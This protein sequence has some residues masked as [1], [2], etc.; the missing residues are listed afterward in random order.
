MV[1]ARGYLLLYVPKIEVYL[2]GS[3]KRFQ[4]A[5]RSMPLIPLN[6]SIAIAAAYAAPMC[7]VHPEQHLSLRATHGF[8]FQVSQA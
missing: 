2:I 5:G 8:L 3:I 7:A 6:R 4:E 1:K